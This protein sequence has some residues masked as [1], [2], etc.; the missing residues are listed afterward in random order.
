[1]TEN[2]IMDLKLNHKIHFFESLEM[3]F[4]SKEAQDFYSPSTRAIPIPLSP[5]RL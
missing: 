5:T 2:M 4:K 3:E 1:M